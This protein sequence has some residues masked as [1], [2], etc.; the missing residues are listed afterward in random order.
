MF[1]S[2]ICSI[3]D[4]QFADD[5]TT[6]TN[7]YTIS[8][9]LTTNEHNSDGW[10]Y[11][12]GSLVWIDPNGATLTNSANIEFTP[13]ECYSGYDGNYAPII[14]YFENAS[15]T[16]VYFTLANTFVQMN[17]STK[18]THSISLN[19]EYRVEYTSNTLKCYLGDTLVGSASHS[20]GTS[21]I[22]VRLATGNGR[23]CRL[24]NFKVKP[25]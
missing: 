14:I 22:K 17:S 23:Y 15:Q 20:L 11:S 1:V 16:R 7:K 19:S 13:T 5:M 4:C 25:L 8:G 12:A 18:T 10:K 9:T 24:K 2:E 3:Q 6:A 21:N